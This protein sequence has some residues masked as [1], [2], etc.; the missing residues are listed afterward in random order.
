MQ[1]RFVILRVLLEAGQGFVTIKKVTGAD[2]KPDLVIS[3]DRSKIIPVGKA[4]IGNFLRKLQVSYGY[5]I[6]FLPFLP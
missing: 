5:H 6:F 3:V 1:A 4:A 2:D